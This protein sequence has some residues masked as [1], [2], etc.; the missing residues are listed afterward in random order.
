MSLFSLSVFSSCVRSSQGRTTSGPQQCRTFFC[1]SIFVFE[2]F[3]AKRLN[4][5]NYFVKKKEKKT[6]PHLDTNTVVFFEE[7]C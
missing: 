2:Y 7:F 5:L 4:L 1:R 6:Q 3:V